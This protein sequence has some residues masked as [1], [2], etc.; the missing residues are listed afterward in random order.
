MAAEPHFKPS[1][2]PADKCRA[3][4]RLRWRQTVLLR[5]MR[6]SERK[7]CLGEWCNN[8][9]AVVISGKAGSIKDQDRPYRAPRSGRRT[10][11]HLG[12]LVCSRKAA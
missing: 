3:G 10:A 1:D 2:A 11:R 4:W 5:Y 8:G 9:E 12:V 7:S 6:R